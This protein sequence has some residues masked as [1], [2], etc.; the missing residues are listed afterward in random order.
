LLIAT[1]VVQKIPTLESITVN[2]EKDMKIKLAENVF[3]PLRSKEQHQK[4]LTF[5]NKNSIKH[6]LVLG[7][8]MESLEFIEALNKEFPDI[9]TTVIDNEKDSTICEY[10]GPDIEKAIVKE[11]T[12]RGVEFYVKV[13][14]ELFFS[15]KYS[16]KKSRKRA[17]E[18]E[19]SVFSKVKVIESQ[20]NYQ[21]SVQVRITDDLRLKADGVVLFPQG[22]SGNTV[23]NDLFRNG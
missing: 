4:L 5:L 6:L 13:Q 19:H 14:D 7:Y 18:A 2:S 21:D 20:P 22:F 11:F 17:L 23:N 8:N 9:K 10:L 15:N 12:S 16:A 1:G 3:C